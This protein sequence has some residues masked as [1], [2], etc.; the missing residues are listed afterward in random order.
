MFRLLVP[1]TLTVILPVFAA[2]AQLPA[3]V[4]ASL[5]AAAATGNA[6]VLE[7]TRQAAAAQHPA[8]AAAI[9]A[10]GQ[11]VAAAPAPEPEGAPAPQTAEKTK[12][13]HGDVE[14]GLNLQ[15]GNTNQRDTLAAAKVHYDIKQWR[16]TFT[17]R[18]RSAYKAKV[19][20]EENYRFGWQT[21]YDL[22]DRQ[23]VFGQADYINDMFSGYNYRIS[24]D[25]GYG[26]FLIKNDDMTL[27]AQV[28]VG[29]Q[30]TEVQVAPNRTQ[31]NSEV[32]LR[33]LVAY[34]WKINDRLT[35]ES[36]GRST[37]AKELVT[38]NLSAGFKTSI[39]QNLAARLTWDIEHLNSVPTGR[40]K[41][42]S[43]T[44]LKLVY[45]F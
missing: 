6:F 19:R 18:A 15:R 30:H 41:T 3:D 9:M 21:A 44:A 35:F 5:A 43:T 8:H 12:N 20:T 2:H 31:M 7:A 1:T 29:G 34:D 39:A 40:K 16:H 17:T 10:F 14:L 37:I 13:W 24:E 25:F 45:D 32:I 22:D 4:E 38:T 23:Y 11:P 36:L 26:R 27:R 42:D 33:P 28:G